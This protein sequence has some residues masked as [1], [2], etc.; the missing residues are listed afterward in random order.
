MKRLFRMIWESYKKYAELFGM[1]LKHVE[2]LLLSLK[3][4]LVKGN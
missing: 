3:R 2:E 1:V 4:P